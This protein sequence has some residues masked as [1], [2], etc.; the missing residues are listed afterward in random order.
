MGYPGGVQTHIRELTQHLL[1]EGH[2]VSVFAPVSN[3][4]KI[5]EEW[6]VSAGK[7]YLFQL[8]A[9]WR[10]FYLVQSQVFE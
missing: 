7:P 4:E 8:M 6:L 9:L 10:E 3:E 5:K 2:Q 1:D